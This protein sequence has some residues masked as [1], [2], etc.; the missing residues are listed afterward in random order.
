LLGG[1]EGDEAIA[2]GLAAPFRLFYHAVGQEYGVRHQ[3]YDQRVAIPAL[4]MIGSDCS[5]VPSQGPGNFIPFMN[6]LVAVADR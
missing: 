5:I 4:S 3:W 2:I 1:E 6:A